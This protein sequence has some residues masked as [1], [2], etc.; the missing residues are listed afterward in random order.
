MM[1][2]FSILALV[3]AMAVGCSTTES[4][5]VGG[6]YLGDALYG[7]SITTP[8]AGDASG[9][10]PITIGATD[11]GGGDVELAIGDAC[12]VAGTRRRDE[13]VHDS[14]SGDTSFIFASQDLVPA[15][16]CTLPVSGGGTVTIT[17]AHGESVVDHGG[18][19]SLDVGG[20]ITAA[21]PGAS[22]DLSAATA[23]Y[24]DLQ[25]EGGGG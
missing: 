17:I 3:L 14:K 2:K 9:A 19:M 4:S 5:D 16:A 8:A 22:A 1:A 18:T 11:T 7:A 21:S 6:T 15:Q 10:E 12:K 20:T 24:F 13:S 23:G 25:F